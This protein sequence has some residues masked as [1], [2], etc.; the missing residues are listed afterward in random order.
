MKSLYLASGSPR[1]YELLQ[2]LQR[3]FTVIRPQVAELRAPDEVAHQY[4]TRLAKDKANAGLQL[5]ATQ[6]ETDQADHTANHAVVM[7]S[8]T[9][10]VVDGDVLEKPADQ[11]DF[12]AMFERLSGRTHQVMTA[13]AVADSEQCFTDMVTTEIHFC[14]I[15][16]Q[17]AADYWS[18]GE[19][20]DK[21]G[22]Y[23][24]QG[25][26]GKFVEYMKGSYSAVVGLPLFETEQLLQRIMDN[27]EV[28]KSQTNTSGDRG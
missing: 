25:Y 17:Q 8:D 5:L 20:A 11:S 21:A 3:P 9:I 18:T 23:A 27:P 1:R 24:I 16:P 26:A 13:V 28:A 4:V 2:L 22:G 19:P 15:S 7:G 10:V 6:T 12:L 14:H